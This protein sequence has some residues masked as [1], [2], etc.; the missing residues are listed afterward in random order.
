MKRTIVQ[1]ETKPGDADENARL[2]ED[3]YAE[4]NESDPGG[5]RYATFRLAD[6]VSFVH[7]ASVE[8]ED[9]S[10]PLFE[11]EAFAEFQRQISDRVV[12]SPNAVD[13]TLV[14]S[15]RLFDDEGTGE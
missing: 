9:D 4:L 10:N 14:G 3:V 13:A 5:L 7:V 15:Y 12:A 6:G 2:V 11:T 1:Y 8:T